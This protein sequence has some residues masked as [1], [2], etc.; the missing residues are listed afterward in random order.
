MSFQACLIWLFSDTQLWK[1]P[2][3]KGL[4]QT[5]LLNWLCTEIAK[6]D[7]KICLPTLGIR[8]FNA[9]H[10]QWQQ[11]YGIYHVYFK[12][13]KHFQLFLYC[14]GKQDLASCQGGGGGSTFFSKPSRKNVTSKEM[15]P[16]LGDVNIQIYFVHFYFDLM[17]R[18]FDFP[19]AHEWLNSFHLPGVKYF[20][21]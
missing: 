1:E 5:F 17:H 7:L 6:L 16:S 9:L 3:S 19:T 21:N 8:Y 13:T 10:F 4:R 2:A 11:P 15:A 20:N 18:Q 14:L 12:S